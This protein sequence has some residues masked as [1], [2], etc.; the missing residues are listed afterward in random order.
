[1]ISSNCITLQNNNSNCISIRVV[2]WLRDVIGYCLVA[3]TCAGFHDAAVMV[4]V[5]VELLDSHGPATDIHQED[6][7]GGS[8]GRRGLR[9]WGEGSEEL[10][11]TSALRRRWENGIAAALGEGRC[12]GPAALGEGRCGGGV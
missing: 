10:G 5:L 4:A 9:R 1:M 12:G 7:S 8:T 6:G 2:C 11:A 3:D